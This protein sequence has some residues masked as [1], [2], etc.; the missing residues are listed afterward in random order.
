MPLDKSDHRSA[1]LPCRWLG[2]PTSMA[3]LKFSQ[4]LD[5]R[6][7]CWLSSRA[8]D[9]NGACYKVHQGARHGAAIQIYLQCMTY[10]WENFGVSGA[11]S[12]T[13]QGKLCL[14]DRFLGELPWAAPRLTLSDGSAHQ[15]TKRLALLSAVQAHPGGPAV[16]NQ[17]EPCTSSPAVAS[18]RQLASTAFLWT[19]WWAWRWQ[20]QKMGDVEL[21]TQLSEAVS[22]PMD[23]SM[24]GYVWDMLGIRLY[25]LCF[26][27][28]LHNA[29]LHSY[30][31]LPAHVSFGSKHCCK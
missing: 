13:A 7:S 1:A 9:Y 15:D 24:P 12:G 19:F 29:D 6:R 8:L 2:E 17:G 18:C 28:A 25:I 20:L 4:W 31:L 14:W 5:H 22:Q 26:V 27:Q 3:Q 16:V 30:L 21:G 10:L 11:V 23:I